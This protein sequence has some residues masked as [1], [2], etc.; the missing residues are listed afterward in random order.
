MKRERNETRLNWV[1]TTC[2]IFQTHFVISSSCICIRLDY[3]I[4]NCW[5]LP[6]N[7]KKKGWKWL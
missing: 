2:T 1:D 5:N 6:F 4:C 7:N 3:G